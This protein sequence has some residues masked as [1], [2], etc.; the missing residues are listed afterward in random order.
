MGHGAV[1]VLRRLKL[2]SNVPAAPWLPMTLVASAPAVHAVDAT[3][4][5]DDVVEVLDVEVLG[6]AV[7]DVEW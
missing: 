7:V 3:L 2:T 5:D 4:D 1:D 6:P